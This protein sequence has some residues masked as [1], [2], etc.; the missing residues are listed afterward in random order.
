M[1]GNDTTTAIQTQFQ[2]DLELSKIEDAENNPVPDKF[3]TS[4]CPELHWN[5]RIGQKSA[6][7]PSKATGNTFPEP[8]FHGTCCLLEAETQSRDNCQVP[9]SNKVWINTEYSMLG[10]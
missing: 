4:L 5:E 1:E 10:T 8:L 6:S 7:L 2:Y 9:I 3:D